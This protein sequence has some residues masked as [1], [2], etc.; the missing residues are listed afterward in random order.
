M[1]CP[2]R[3]SSVVIICYAIQ[4]GG[5]KSEAAIVIR[6]NRHVGLFAL[7]SVLDGAGGLDAGELGPLGFPG[8]AAS[9]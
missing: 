5:E 4:A 9:S 7:L 8:G 2:W 1:A 6:H 3:Y